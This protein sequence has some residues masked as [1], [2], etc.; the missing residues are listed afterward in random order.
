[1]RLG[2]AVALMLL[3]A[4]VSRPLAAQDST[5][6]VAKTGRLAGQVIDRDTGR[7]L[8]AALIGIIGPTLPA[9]VLTTDLD[10]R[11]R[12]EP[13]PVGHYT[14]QASVIGYQ[15]TRV[16]SA[17]V[18]ENRT[19]IVNLA[20]KAVPFEL[21]A[22]SVEAVAVPRPSSE[23][24]LLSM[25]Q[26]APVVSDGVSAETIKRTPDA[27]ASDAL[28][29]VTGVAIVDGKFV[30]IRG[31]PERYSNT[32]LN[33]AELVST[34]PVK[35]IVPLDIFPASL[36]ES[37]VTFKTATPDRPGDFAGG[38]VSITT[39][40]F[41]EQF[42]MQFSLSQGYSS[43]STFRSVPLVATSS[44]D[45]LG[46]DNGRRAFPNGAP[47]I[48]TIGSERFA[49]SIRNVWTPEPRDVGPDLGLKFN[50]GGRWGEAHPLGYVFAWTYTDKTAY[51]PDRLY[52]LYPDANTPPFRALRFNDSHASVEWGT[53]FNMTYAAGAGSKFGWKNLYTRQATEDVVRSAGYE[54]VNDRVTQA[55]QVRY[56]A[57][58]LLQT[59]LTGDHQLGLFDSRFEWKGTL[60][61]A[62]RDEPDNRQAV[63][64]SG[65]LD[66]GYENPTIWTRFLTDK[67]VAAQADWSIPFGVRQLRDAQFKMGGLLRRRARDFDSRF[68]WF[69]PT[70][71]PGARNDPALSL[72]PELV[73]APE[74]IGRIM[75]LYSPG[76]QA[77]P[78]GADDNVDAAYVMADLPVLPFLR[79]VGGV[80][81]EDW[82]LRILPGGRGATNVE[83]QGSQHAG[84][85]LW[86]ANATIRLSGR[87]NFR[88]AGFR[89]VARPDAREVTQNVYQGVVGE[90]AYAGSLNLVRTWINNGDVRWEMY[91]R[92]GELLAVS[93]FYKGFHSP[94][95]EMA[96]YPDG[97]R[98]LVT[99]RNATYAQDYGIEVE[100]RKSLGPFAASM[101]VTRVKSIV[102]IDTVYGN[103]EADLPLQGQ[104]PWLANGMLSYN[105]ARI[106]GTVSI[107]YFSDRVARYGIGSAA[108]PVQA[109][110]LLEQSRA[111]VDAKVQLQL[112]R[113]MTLAFAGKNLT[114]AATQFIHRATAG[115]VLAQQS[116]SGI[117]ASLE[118]GY[119][120]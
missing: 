49:E 51:N 117:G 4:S 112:P 78:Y 61:L 102:E 69:Q 38:S 85:L 53:V 54:A 62:G 74:N 52:F 92:P 14:I 77:E 76:G 35:R 56:V 67:L 89:S 28:K 16:D 47:S 33:G 70:S 19:E 2:H 87:M 27:H 44:S 119:A 110:N 106:S 34:E 5:H 18:L 73:F 59:Q 81:Y 57:E 103:F 63:Y 43:R 32:L 48:G 113:R 55:Y 6:A 11:Y 68:F 105:G 65:K 115:T 8:P 58:H 36:L 42:V 1:M 93:A 108:T 12:S 118:L 79:L 3:G 24:G 37:I 86:S 75:E 45:R 114:N 26:S 116:Q 109:P 41:P 39:K 90:C 88:L 21:S 80:R 120:F 98:C 82:H 29:R 66:I 72:A 107:N 17:R 50:I 97:L 13:L 94:I 95:V 9:L 7:P 91:P 99:Y 96:S 23:A 30:I 60:A 40:E 25:Q 20:L 46:F 15:T 22:V 111:T 104:S 10:G 31:L 64:S 84:D 71:A 100:V 101:N 83:G